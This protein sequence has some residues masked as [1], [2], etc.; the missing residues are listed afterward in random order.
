MKKNIVKSI[1]IESSCEE[2]WESLTNPG[3]ISQW[4]MPTDNF[5]AIAGENF[6]MQAKPMGKW[7]GRIYGQILIA[8]APHVLSYTWKGDQMNSDT[9]VKWTLKSKDK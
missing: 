3:D 5:K 6:T 7:D 4:L 1:F 8:Q 2:I 9:V